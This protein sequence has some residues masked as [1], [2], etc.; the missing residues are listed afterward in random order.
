M[1]NKILER[2][3]RLIAFNTQSDEH[4]A[5][6]PSTPEQTAFAHMLAI[7][8]EHIGLQQVRISPYGIVSAVLPANTNKPAIPIGF[9]AHMDTAP[10][11]SGKGIQAQV[12]TNYQGE[13]IALS[14]EVTLS[15]DMF[16]QMLQYK[17]CTLITTNGNTLLGADDKAGITEIMCA[18]EYLITHPHI[19]HGDIHIAFTPDEEIGCGADH[20]NIS[21]F[22]ACYAYTVDGG[23]EGEL[24]YENFNAARADISIHGTNVHPGSAKNIMVNAQHIAMELHRMLPPADTPEH[25]CNK[26]G[27]FHLCHMQGSVE[28]TTMNYII[29]DHDR[30]KFE[31]KKQL[32]LQCVNTLNSLYGSCISCHIEDQYY[33]MGEVIQNHYFIV[34]LAEKS[35]REAGA[36]PLIVPI[37]GGT[38]GAILSYM[39]LPCP[40][41]FT[42][43]HNF[44]GKY[45]FAVL[46]SM[47][48]ACMT[49]VNICKN[50]ALI[51]Q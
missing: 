17:G 21:E 1:T 23:A 5:T 40:N 41:L 6:V 14:K 46:E 15:P 50:F 28:L 30:Q 25:T 18:M 43:G 24:E 27:F 8:L 7:E 26:E 4:S 32:L 2:F 44:H 47:H 11:F 49:I 31:Q 20:F 9:I 48:K 45:E 37:R 39:G 29:R 34:E 42:G 38:D 12:H 16:P 10:D 3:L 22:Q 33:N 51:N 13:D 35:I 19:A 36:V